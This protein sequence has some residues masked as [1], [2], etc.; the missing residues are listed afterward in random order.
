MEERE[1]F[2]KRTKVFDSVLKEP[3]RETTF[4]PKDQRTR[5]KDEL[6]QVIQEKLEWLSQNWKEAF[7]D[8]STA[9]A[10]T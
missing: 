1:D 6:G 2:K 8:T 4:I 7:S 5:R 10:S 3:V 9:S